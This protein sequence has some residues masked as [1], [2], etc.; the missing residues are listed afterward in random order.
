MNKGETMPTV[1]D[2]IAPCAVFPSPKGENK[3]GR[4][5]IFPAEHW[6]KWGGE[7]G[8]Y[9]VMIDQT[10]LSRVGERVSF[11]DEDGLGCVLRRWGLGVLGLGL[12]VPAP[13]TVTYTAPRG[14]HVWFRDPESGENIPART[15]SFPFQDEQGDW[16]V[17]L[18]YPR[19]APAVPLDYLTL[20][21]RGEGV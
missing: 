1:R 8:L 6:G 14:T 19:R 11:Y 13:G 12:D 18:L 3:A 21:N 16:R 4:L 17:Y 15:N 20:R 7:P 9:R 5:S 2:D 10:W